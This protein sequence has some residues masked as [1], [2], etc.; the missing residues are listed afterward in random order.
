MP[1]GE[2]GGPRPEEL[3]EMIRKAKGGVPEG[4][5]YA[6]TEPEIRIPRETVQTIWNEEIDAYPFVSNEENNEQKKTDEEV[7]KQR[8]ECKYA[9]HIALSEL[10]GPE[11]YFSLRGYGDFERRLF[12]QQYWHPF[13]QRFPDIGPHLENLAKRIHSRIHLE[14][15]PEKIKSME[16][17][18]SAAG[19]P[20][21]SPNFFKRH[22]EKGAQALMG[23]V[24]NHIKGFDGRP[25]WSLVLTRLSSTAQEKFSKKE[26]AEK[27]ADEELIPALEKVIDDSV[28]THTYWTPQLV[29][30]KRKT[31]YE[32]LRKKFRTPAAR[33]DI[34]DVSESASR[35]NWHTILLEL[36]EEKRKTFRWAFSREMKY[37]TEADAVQE[38]NDILT[39][40]QP[41]KWG[42]RWLEENGFSSIRLYW[43]HHFR[44]PDGKIDWNRLLRQ[45]PENL[46]EGFIMSEGAKIKK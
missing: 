8:N 9:T 39:Q 15:S 31:L 45:L 12:Q 23:W 30:H 24:R 42:P 40:W 28:V 11:E 26:Q 29:F 13:I 14:F 4:E 21:W 6:W 3:T 34:G 38:I 1:I 20:E 32:R 44:L 33:P 16:N 46:Q 5:F 41:Q 18:L 17:Y 2:G 25:D 27:L 35:P 43:E 7:E 19:Y 37:R 22:T 36:P 10:A